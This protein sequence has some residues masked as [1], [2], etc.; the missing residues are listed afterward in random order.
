MARRTGQEYPKM[1]YGPND[2]QRIIQKDDQM[3]AGFVEHPSLLKKKGA[4][5]KPKDP[6]KDP[7]PTA[8]EKAETIKSLREAGIDIAD[9][10]S[11]EDINAAID[12]LAEKENAK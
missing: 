7:E 5:S 4:G 8:E 9:D 2:E 12:L 3:P 10:A 6:P 11:V 1:V